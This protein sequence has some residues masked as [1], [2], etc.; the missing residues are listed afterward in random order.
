MGSTALP[1]N[2]HHVCNRA[3]NWDSTSDSVIYCQ[4][5][6]LSLIDGVGIANFI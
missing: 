1:M 4:V 2:T 3:L 5:L 6:L